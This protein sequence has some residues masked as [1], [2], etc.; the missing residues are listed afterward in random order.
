MSSSDCN[1]VA[2]R[3]DHVTKTY[4]LY[5]ND[6]QRFLG[7][8]RTKSK[9]NE[10]A[11]INASDDLSFDIKRGEAVALLGHNG[12]GKSTALKMITGVTFPTEGKVEVNGSVSALLELTAGFDSNLSGRENIYL[13]G[14]AL[15]LTQEQ[16]AALEPKVIEFAELGVYIDQPVRT[17]S[18][19][20]KARLGFAFAVSSDP[21]ILVVDEALSVGDKKFQA[22]CFKR[23]REI[24]ENE[25]T[26]VIFVT[27]ASAAAQEFCTRGIVFNH[28]KKVFDGPI[29]DA[30][31]FY[32]ESQV[33]A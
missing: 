16:I 7:I 2:I 21:E 11:R 24:M 27:H 25:T 28:G 9:R 23:V 20:M 1:D 18:S 33:N 8:F 22:K 15:G 14:H 31:N 6:T 30:I 12:A 4:K 3:F 26:T 5:E 19:G 29:Q 32:E 10:V 17:Y 13:R